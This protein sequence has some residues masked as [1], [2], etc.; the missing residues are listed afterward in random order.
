MAIEMAAIG[1]APSLT[2]AA[3]MVGAAPSTIMHRRKG[4]KNREEEGERRQKLWPE[5]ER[6]VIDR[7]YFRCRL[8][9]PPTVWQLREIATSVVRKRN[10]LE[11]LGKWWEEAFKKR[12][13]EVKSR[14]SKQLD[15][16]QNIRGN[17]PQL[18]N[19]FFDEVSLYL[20]HFISF[21]C[22]LFISY[23]VYF[24]YCLF[25]VFYLFIYLFILFILLYFNLLIYCCLF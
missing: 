11:T 21:S 14:F 2:V 18:M 13:P 10:P 23:I 24:L 5:E 3:G 8:G 16:I 1:T 22:F 19:H 12:H 6:A 9:F 20:F 15:F 17:D 7:C 25:L 4:R